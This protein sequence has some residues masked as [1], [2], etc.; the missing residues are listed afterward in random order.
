[1]GKNDNCFLFWGNN[2]SG[3]ARSI[4]DAGFYEEKETSNNDPVVSKDIVDKFKEKVILPQYGERKE[5][6]CSP[7]RKVGGS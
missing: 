6:Y 1:M 2:A 4:E 5:T 3:Y 7:R